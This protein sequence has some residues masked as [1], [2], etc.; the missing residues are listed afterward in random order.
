M[1]Y[2]QPDATWVETRRPAVAERLRAQAPL[3]LLLAATAALYL[4]GLDRS[5]YANEFYAAAVKSGTQS[6]KAFL[7]GSLDPSNFITVDKPPASLWLMEISGRLFG[8]SSWSMLV[9]QA[10]AGVAS[11]WLVHATVKRW[12]SLHA[13]LL[14]GVILT[15]TPVA[16]LMFRFNNPDALLVLL[17][18]AAAYATTRAIE[19]GSA[20]WLALAGAAVGFGFLTK[21]MEA[22][23]VLPALAAAYAVAAP[24]RLRR[25]IAHVLL[26]GVALVVAGGWWVAI[27]E[28]TPASARPYVGG[29]TG[30]SVLDL[31]LGYNGLGRIDGQGAGNGASFSGSPGLLRL[32]NSEMGTQISWLLPAA[33]LALVYGLVHAARRPRTDRSRAA[34]IVWGGWLAVTALVFSYMSGV[35]HPYY[36]NLLAPPIAVLVGVS[37]VELWHRRGNL[38]AAVG[39]A[40]MLIATSAWSY[41]LLERTPSWHPLLRT[42]V[43]VGGLVAGVALVAV[44]DSLRRQWSAALAVVAAGAALAAPVGYTLATAS[45][46]ESGSIVAAGPGG[47]GGGLGFGGPGGGTAAASSALAT[48]VSKSTGYRWAAATSSSM[49]AA[50]LELATGKAVMAI[51]GFTGS[52]RAIT[53]AAFKQLVAR[54]EIHYY[55]AGGGGGGGF[56]GGGPGGG[57][58]EIESWVASTFSSTTVGGT[59]VYDLGAGTTS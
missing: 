49:T 2:A 42:F 19:G 46:V 52:D 55:V 20:R 43:L 25:R 39:L 58:G 10:L 29:S 8:F 40:L 35:I 47:T 28:L 51:G 41:V 17:L 13:A 4:W 26:A 27:V 15:V 33:L 1:T 22:F 31:S 9:P 12:F 48:L 45:S 38:V 7:F 30:N 53:L 5:G 57:N 50:P 44:T 23:L 56:G 3:G 59:T 36:T 37:S 18:V 32:F 16:A 11:V 24:G 54:H 21:M 34:L 6:W 14:S